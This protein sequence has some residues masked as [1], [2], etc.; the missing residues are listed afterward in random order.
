MRRNEDTYTPKQMREEL[1]INLSQ[2]PKNLLGL[3]KT[4]LIQVKP[5][6]KE[7]GKPPESSPDNAIYYTGDSVRKLKAK[8]DEER[9]ENDESDE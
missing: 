6:S 9:E 4:T 3:L 2:V 7:P 5:E 8:L 1:N